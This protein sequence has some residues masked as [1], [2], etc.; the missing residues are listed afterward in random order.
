MIN[1]CNQMV[2]VGFLKKSLIGHSKGLN[3]QSYFIMTFI[4]IIMD[5]LVHNF[6]KLTSTSQIEYVFLRPYGYITTTTIVI[7]GSNWA[8]SIFM[9]YGRVTGVWNLTHSLCHFV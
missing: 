3:Q 5:C 6:A 2:Y 8:I 9:G 1:C 7:I 4:S